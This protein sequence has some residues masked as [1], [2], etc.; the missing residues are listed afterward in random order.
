MENCLVTKVKGVVD[1]DNL[2]R[3]GI[4]RVFIR[5]KANFG[6]PYTVDVQAGKITTPFRFHAYT[7]DNH[8]WF[9]K[10]NN[11]VTGEFDT[12]EW[13]FDVKDTSNNEDSFFDVDIYNTTMI[14][15]NN[16]DISNSQTWSGAILVLF[17]TWASSRTG[18]SYTPQGNLASIAEKFPNVQNLSINY[19]PAGIYGDIKELSKLIN[20]YNLNVANQTYKIEGSINALAEGMIANGRTTGTLEITCN[21]IITLNE[22]IVEN[23]VKK[24]VTFQNGSYTVTDPE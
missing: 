15:L 9:G 19:V 20:L 22:T 21:G 5:D 6:Y 11:P 7:T 4:E 24:I 3:L 8:S 2:K 12:A 23:N 16:I 17:G 14:E 10:E 18:I 13:N 1:N